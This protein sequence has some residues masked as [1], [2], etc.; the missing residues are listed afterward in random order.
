MVITDKL[1][2]HKIWRNYNIR[3]FSYALQNVG[4]E[5][6]TLMV[7]VDAEIVNLPLDCHTTVSVCQILHQ[8]SL[9]LELSSD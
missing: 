5:L 1:V 6:K 7:S 8:F 2:V 9:L 4:A 3:R